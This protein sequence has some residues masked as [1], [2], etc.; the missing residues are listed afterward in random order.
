MIQLECVKLVKSNSVFALVV[1]VAMVLMWV[2]FLVNDQV[3]ELATIPIEITFSIIADNA[4]AV[5]LIISGYGLYSE[6]PWGPDVFLV[7]M[8]AL[9]Y[10]LMIAIGYYAQLGEIPMLGLFVPIFILMV[11]FTWTRIKNDA[12]PSKNEN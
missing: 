10:S 12:K 1:G 8:G 11:Y 3:P 4:T 5:L 9:F 2:F 6:K 7:S